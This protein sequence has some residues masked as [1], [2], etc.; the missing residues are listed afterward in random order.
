MTTTKS[1]KKISLEVKRLIKAPPEKVFE[2]WINPDQLMKWFCPETCQ[3]LSAKTDP[4]VGGEYRFRVRSEKFGEMVVCGS[5]REVKKP[6]RLAFTWGWEDPDE[7][8][9]E[10]FVTVNFAE[11]EGGT[12]VRLRH[13]GFATQESRE[14]HNHGWDGCLGKLEK[15]LECK[16]LAVGEFC[17]NELVTN[18]LQGAGKFYSQLFSWKAE[19]FPGMDYTLFKQGEKS[20]GGMMQCQEKNVPPF[21]LAY[22]G[23]ENADAS[24]KRAVELGARIIKA[25]FDI[26]TVGRLAVIQ[27]PQGA[28][29]AVFQAEKK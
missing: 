22:V 23:V 18:D 20:L 29:F 11:V 3:I 4:K 1:S 6:S 9:V 8:D 14:N 15:L 2:A 19:P 5:Y 28:T 26:P 13:E 17:W 25:P 12:E 27:D 16:G 7:N 21:W 10:T 24:A